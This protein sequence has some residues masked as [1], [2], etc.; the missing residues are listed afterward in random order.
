LPEKPAKKLGGGRKIDH[1]KKGKGKKDRQLRKK[2]RTLG[3][4][5]GE[6]KTAEG[7]DQGAMDKIRI[8]GETQKGMKPRKENDRGAMS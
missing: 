4:Y 5:F 3:G 1:T 6:H 2:S 7:K 8:G